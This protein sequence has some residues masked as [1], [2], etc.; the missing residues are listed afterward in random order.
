MLHLKDSA[1]SAEVDVSVLATMCE[2]YSG[3]DIRMVCR[4]AA[5]VRRRLLSVLLSVLLSALLCSPLL[6]SPHRTQCSPLLFSPRAHGMVLPGAQRCIERPMQAPM[7]RLIVE[8]PDPCEI[9]R[10]KEVIPP[11]ARWSLH[12]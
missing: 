9:A 11:T 10:L 12:D 8:L 7:R 6:S 5:M 1:L 2:G 4:E 3:A